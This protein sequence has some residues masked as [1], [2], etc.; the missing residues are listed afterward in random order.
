VNNNHYD[1][2]ENADNVESDA[3]DEE[4]TSVSQMLADFDAMRA[5]TANATADSVVEALEVETQVVVA[6]ESEQSEEVELVM[7]ATAVKEEQLEEK[8]SSNGD[9]KKGKWFSWF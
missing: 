3:V 5:L 8:G 1:Y 6:N 9:T 7:T 2:F 4:M